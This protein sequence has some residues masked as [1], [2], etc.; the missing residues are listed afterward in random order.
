MRFRSRFVAV[1]D[2][3][4]ILLDGAEAAGSGGLGGACITPEVDIVARTTADV[5]D[6]VS[7]RRICQANFSLRSSFVAC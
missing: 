1:R 2:S 7:T 3:G 6:A 5:V 4:R